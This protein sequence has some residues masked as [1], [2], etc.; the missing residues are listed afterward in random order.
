MRHVYNNSQNQS[1]LLASSPP[2]SITNPFQQLETS[3]NNG[4]ASIPILHQQLPEKL[5]MKKQLIDQENANLLQRLDNAKSS[6]PMNSNERKQKTVL[7]G[8]YRRFAS[9]YDGGKPRL[10]PLIYKKV[11]SV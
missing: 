10:D 4:A 1:Q 6:I 7:M 8:N 9:K 11:Q 3:S 5:R 2:K